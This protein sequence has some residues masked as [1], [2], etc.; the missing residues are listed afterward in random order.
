LNEVAICGY[1]AGE[2]SLD[3]KGKGMGMRFSP[4]IQV[5]R[6]GG[7]LPFDDAPDPYGI[8]TDIIGV[9]G[10]SGSPLLDPND[11]NVIGIAQRVLPADVEV[12][13]TDFKN[14]KAK[15]FGNAKIGQVYGLT[16]YIIHP[17][18]IAVL[19]YFKTRQ[20]THFKVNTTGLNFNYNIQ[21]GE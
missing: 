11:G 13:F 20:H 5:G 10:S 14:M 12:N 19:Q 4:V 7:L 17:A 9:G 16:N 3:I 8:Q 6:I 2:H 1:P 18:T 15:G 21:V